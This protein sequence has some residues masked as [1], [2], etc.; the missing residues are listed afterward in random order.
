M[1]FVMSKTRIFENKVT[2]PSGEDFTAKFLVLK[3]EDVAK[4]EALENESLKAFLTKVL[5]GW[6]GIKV[7]DDYEEP[8]DEYFSTEFR[9]HILEYT[10]IRVALQNAYYAGLMGA[11]SG[12]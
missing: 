12:N 6:S 9:A 5:V 11:K 7:L 8:Q 4:F 1:T 3:D 10:D 2:L